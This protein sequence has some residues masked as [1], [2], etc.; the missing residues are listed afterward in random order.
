M[1]LFPQSYFNLY[2]GDNSICILWYVS[3]ECM[4]IKVSFPPYWCCKDHVC[5]PLTPRTGGTWLRTAMIDNCWM[6]E[7]LCFTNSPFWHHRRKVGGCPAPLQWAGVPSPSCFECWP[8]VVLSFPPGEWPSTEGLW[9]TWKHSSP[10][11][12]NPGSMTG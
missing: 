3:Y 9:L 6:N 12:S 7:Y 4:F 10:Q 5:L 8:L 11:S 1:D 2:F